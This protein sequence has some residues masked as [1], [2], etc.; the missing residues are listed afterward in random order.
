MVLVEVWGL[1]WRGLREVYRE[2]GAGVWGIGDGNF[3][4][5]GNRKML[6]LFFK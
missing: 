3:I 1:D 6:V 5:E 2:I 4:R